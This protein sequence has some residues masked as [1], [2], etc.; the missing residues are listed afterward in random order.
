MNC[1]L[2]IRYSPPVLHHL[3]NDYKPTVNLT[4]SA[5]N[6]LTTT[7]VSNH[8]II[9]LMG[10]LFRS[11]PFNKHPPLQSYMLLHFLCQHASKSTIMTM[12]KEKSFKDMPNIKE[13]HKN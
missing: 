2:N 8:K 3:D 13:I 7:T 1:L 6:D 5:D 12:F 10:K 4:I 9:P 11:T